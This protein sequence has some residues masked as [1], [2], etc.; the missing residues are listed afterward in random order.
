MHLVAVCCFHT[1]RHRVNYW[2]LVLLILIAI[3]H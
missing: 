3:V 1:A 2:V